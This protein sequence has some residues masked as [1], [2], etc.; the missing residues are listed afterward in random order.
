[1]QM[2]LLE[3]LFALGQDFQD[4]VLVAKLKM[5]KTNYFINQLDF[6]M[7]DKNFIRMSGTFINFM[8]TS[9]LK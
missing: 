9:R 7:L 5:V 6:V 8:Y 4:V 3:R 1:M 2:I